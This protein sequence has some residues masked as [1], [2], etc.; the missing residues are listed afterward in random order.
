MHE[1]I[2]QLLAYLRGMWHRRWLGL[3]VAWGVG[4]IGVIVAYQIPQKFEASARVY[5]DTESLLRPL[6]QGLAFQPNVAQQVSLISRTLVS[7]PN[8][9]KLVR[10][11]DLDLNV[12]PGPAHDALVDDVMKTI[13]LEGNV[14]SNLYVISYRDANPA[15]ARKVVQSLLSIFMES[16]LGDKREDTRTAVRFI[17]EQI[18]RYEDALQTIENKI[19]DFRLKYMGVSNSRE[20]HD[21]FERMSQLNGEIEAA[22]LELQSAEQAREAYKKQIAGETPVYL[23]EPQAASAPT[24]PTTLDT[25]LAKLKEDL[26]GLLRKYTDQHPDV[27]ATRRLISELEDQKKAALEAQRAALAAT[28]AARPNVEQNPVM[29]QLRISFANSEAAVASAR[30]KLEGLQAQYQHLKTQ[31]QLIPQVEAEFTQLKR[32]YDVQKKTYD[33]LVSRREA[34]S[35]GRD[36]QDTS[37][38][39]F[40]IIDPPRVSPQP[41]APNRLALLGVVFALSLLA[42][43]AASFAASQV[44]PIFHDARALRDATKRPILGM[45]SML[46]SD[47]LHRLTWRNAWL[48]AGGVTGL[49]A[50]F[51]AVFAFA[52]VTGGRPI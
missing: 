45:V 19:K 13:K 9:E 1:V 12:A 25:R 5:V 20:G 52:F 38:A 17:D 32:D 40:R 31:A 27:L 34:A 51:G 37:G 29:Q 50:A 26:D 15:R 7:R 43:M 6:L 11:A 18:K 39:R 10:Q 8:V 44:A 42:G 2:N 30:A 16:S 33:N 24:A 35:M 21:Y 46:Q 47:A 28:P 48:Y 14:S 22:R 3:A 36:V 23:P 4:A 41:V 49:A